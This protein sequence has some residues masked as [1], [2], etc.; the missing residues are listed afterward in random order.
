MKIFISILIALSL[1]ACN[2][3]KNLPS[4]ENTNAV[5]TKPAATDTKIV[6]NNKCHEDRKVTK[7]VIDAKMTMVYIMNTYMFANESKRYQACE[8]PEEF[9]QEGLKVKLSGQVLEIRPNERRAGSPF[10]ITALSRI[11]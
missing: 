9:H 1:T 3:K 5:T 7:E 10:N 4:P 11:E 2:Q 8:V 6:Y